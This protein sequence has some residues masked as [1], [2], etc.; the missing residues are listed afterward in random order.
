LSLADDHASPA[1]P[2]YGDETGEIFDTPD[3]VLESPTTTER[4]VDTQSGFLVVVRRLGSRSSLS[5]KRRLGTPP[6]SS[7]VL[8]P[9]E[10]LQLSRILSGPQAETDVPIKSKA[11]AVSSNLNEW[12]TRFASNALEREDE[13]LDET[14]SNSPLQAN[15]LRSRF[16]SRRPVLDKFIYSSSSL[17]KGLGQ[18]AVLLSLVTLAALSTGVLLANHWRA[19]LHK[20]AVQEVKVIEHGDPTNA[21]IDKFVRS[22]VGNMLDFSPESYRLSQIQAMSVMTPQLV[23]KYWQETNFPIAEKQLKNGMKRETLV[24]TK[25]VQQEPL[26]KTTRVVDVFA[27]LNAVDGKTSLPTHLQ[28]KLALTGNQPDEIRV[29]EQNDLTAS[30]KSA[31]P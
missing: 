5:V 7:I 25:V 16:Q 2:F 29:T 27:Q 1:A 14:L 26:D 23:S 11:T 21:D 19:R 30:D 18:R 15:E 6:S 17:G 22:Y 24:I 10:S 20:K 4:V 9:D 8:T 31:S 3:L 28:L 13:T 12:S